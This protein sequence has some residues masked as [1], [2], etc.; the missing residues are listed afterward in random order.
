[1]TDIGEGNSSSKPSATEEEK[2]EEEEI[3]RLKIRFCVF[4][5]GTGNNLVNIEEREKNTIHYQDHKP[6]PGKDANSYEGD[7]TNVAKM[8]GYINKK[9]PGEYDYLLSTYIEGPGTVNMGEDNWYGAGFGMGDTGVKDKVEK[10]VD[11][12]VSIVK[13][14]LDK[15]EVVEE[16]VLDVFGFS[17]GAAG[18]RYFIYRALRDNALADVFEEGKENVRVEFV[19]LY[20]TVSSE[21]TDHNDV[22]SL[23]LKS[24]GRSK[25]KGVLHL[26]A[27]DEHRGYFACTNINSAGKKG[28]QICLPGAHSDIGGG[29]RADINGQPID[30]EL[31][32]DES[33]DLKRLKKDRAKLVDQGW[34]NEDQIVIEDPSF[35]NRGSAPLYKLKSSRTGI[36]NG[37]AKIPLNIMAKFFC[38]TGVE[39][40][41]EFDTNEEIPEHLSEAYDALGKYVEDKG[42][43]G[44][45]IE[46]WKD[47]VEDE[48]KDWL[49]K[50]RNK[51]LHFSAH[52]NTSSIPLL[53]LTPHFPNGEL[54]PRKRRIIDG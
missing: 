5:D 53:K 32:L 35:L 1:M 12:V 17:R 39:L 40:R 43:E 23:K 10:G 26:V 50:I 41:L 42:S 16:L 2:P 46:D 48:N 22:D 44:S 47:K 34:F 14:K 45:K 37:Y 21:G 24:V 36:D 4:F 18:A 7:K 29:Y 3:T 51:H 11:D 28:T 49:K 9:E 13:G 31:I 33:G 15:N 30:E 20:D 38:E 8:E 52:Y 19:G 6:K 25:V 54:G 27:A